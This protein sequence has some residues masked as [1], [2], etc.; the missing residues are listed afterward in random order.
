MTEAGG[1][2]V[3]LAGKR[4]ERGLPPAGPWLVALHPIALRVTRD[5]AHVPGQLHIT[6]GAGKPAFARVD[7]LGARRTA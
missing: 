4:R 7:R 6:R 2:V 5:P 1:N 3:S